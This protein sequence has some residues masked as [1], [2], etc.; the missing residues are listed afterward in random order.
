MPSALRCL[1]LLEIMAGHPC[2]ISLTE[3]ACALS[4]PTSSA[5]RIIS[6]LISAGF[7]DQDSSTRRYS[8]TGKVLWIGTAFLRQ[9]EVYRSTYG[10]MQRLAQRAEIMVHLGVW[11]DGTVLY[12]HTTGPPQSLYRFTDI[13]ERQPAYCTALGK[14]LLAYRSPEEVRRALGDRPRRHT[15]TTITSLPEMNEELQKIRETGYAVDNG[16]QFPN[17]RCVAAPIRNEHREVIAALSISGSLQ[18]FADARLSEFANLVQETALKASIQL[19]FRPIALNWIS[20][21][22]ATS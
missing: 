19:G 18:Q 2:D 12:L 9:A 10:A 1:R 21:S 6:T 15:D 22:S 7:I 20:D 13:G 3:I 16:E 11:D 17:V 14:V 4:V 8:L 5:H